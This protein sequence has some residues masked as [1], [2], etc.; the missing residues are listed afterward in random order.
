MGQDQRMSQ[1]QPKIIIKFHSLQNFWLDIKVM[2]IV[3]KEH[4][5]LIRLGSGEEKQTYYET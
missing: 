2:E 4:I 5:C 3:I 1:V